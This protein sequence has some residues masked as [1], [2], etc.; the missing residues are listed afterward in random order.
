MSEDGNNQVTDNN[1]HIIDIGR[2]GKVTIVVDSSKLK[3]FM[4]SVLVIK[5]CIMS[6]V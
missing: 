6:T 4:Q 3:Q 1:V 5:T 2:G